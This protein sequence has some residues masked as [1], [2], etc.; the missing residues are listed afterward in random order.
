MLDSTM[1]TFMHF[2][3]DPP[4]LKWIKVG[5]KGLGGRELRGINGHCPES[6]PCPS[7]LH[8][9]GTAVKGVG[10]DRIS[11]ET[12][13]DPMI[14]ICKSPDAEYFC[15]PNPCHNGGTCI[16]FPGHTP[17]YTCQCDLGYDDTDCDVSVQVL[18]VNPDKT[19][20]W[21]ANMSDFVFS[22]L[23]E[24]GGSARI[25]NIYFDDGA[26]ALFWENLTT[27]GWSIL[28]SQM[29][30]DIVMVKLGMPNRTLISNTREDLNVYCMYGLQI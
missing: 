2:D 10:F 12:A 1:E 6:N 20:L 17:A 16:A 23:I 25:G 30:F 3:N 21:V 5:T 4:F 19:G 15:S 18:I 24:L 11:T 13:E 27:P 14:V 9:D 26:N 22:S 29:T 28:R 7:S 8:F